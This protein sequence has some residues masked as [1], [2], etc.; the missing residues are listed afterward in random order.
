M[1]KQLLAFIGKAAEIKEEEIDTAIEK[2]AKGNSEDFADKLNEFRNRKVA[3]EIWDT[4]YT[5]QNSLCSILSDG[6]LDR[7]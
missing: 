1:W 6:E 7:S 2:I 4:Y 5:L 3:D